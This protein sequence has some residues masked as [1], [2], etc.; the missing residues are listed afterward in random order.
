VSND[1]VP[2]EAKLPDRFDRSL[3]PVLIRQTIV[4]G[5]RGQPDILIKA[6]WE[7]TKGPHAKQDIHAEYDVWV[8]ARMMS[9]LLSEYPRH[10]WRC[11]H[12]SIQGV[13]L[14]SNWILMG[15]GN[16][17]AVNLKTH[18]LTPQLIIRMGGE[19]LERYGLP[20]GKLELGSFLEARQK[21]SAL[22]IKTRKVP[23]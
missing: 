19:I 20:R 11:R 1:L 12:D 14:I 3:D 8:A 6:E 13:A 16:W 5:E 21:H 22:V 17:M 9:I 23:T 2:H 15:M 18:E 10:S 7:D 4:E